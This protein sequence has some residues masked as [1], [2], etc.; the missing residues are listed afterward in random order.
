MFLAGLAA[1]LTMYLLPSGP[2]TIDSLRELQPR[3]FGALRTSWLIAIWVLPEGAGPSGCSTLA[4]AGF[5]EVSAP[6][7]TLVVASVMVCGGA[8]PICAI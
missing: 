7:L 3:F 5:A 2:S 1:G 6:L 8:Q 4:L